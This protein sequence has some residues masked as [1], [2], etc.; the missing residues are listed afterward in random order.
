MAD[1]LTARGLVARPAGARPALVVLGGLRVARQR[2][3]CRRGHRPR[4]DVRRDGRDVRAGPVGTRGLRRPAGRAHRPG[5]RRPRVPRGP[6]CCIS[7]SSGS[8]REDDPGLRRQVLRFA[9]SV[10]GSTALLL[11]AS[12]LDGTAQTLTW[13][14]ALVASTTSA[15]SSRGVRVAAELRRPLRRASR[16]DPDRRA[17]RVDRRDRR[18]RR[19]AADLD[20]DHRRLGRSAS[21]SR[22]ASGGRTST[23]SPSSPSACSAER[24]GRS[25]ARL[26]RDAY[27]YL[28]L[29][30]IAG[31]ILLALGLK[32]L[33]EYVGDAAHHD[34]ADPLPTLPLAAMYGGVA[35]YLARARSR[36]STA[37]C[38]RS[39]CIASWSRYSS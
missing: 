8:P 22:G 19:A 2:R 31:I 12:Q 16:A 32:K 39:R 30:M 37:S 17:R 15:R 4:G 25:A 18:R 1:D 7:R 10:V 36:S 29:P 24:R 27:S 28:H 5:R 9:P 33:L 38:E 26:A 6:R 23:S 11:V 3:P 35:L 34:L 20:A 21:R 14:A 13:A